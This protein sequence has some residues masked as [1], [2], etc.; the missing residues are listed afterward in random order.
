MTFRNAIFAGGGSRC[1]WQLGFWEGAKDAGLDLQTSVKFIGST[2][3]GCAMASAAVLD[4]ALDALELFKDLTDKNPK[5]VHW[6]NIHP[7]RREPLLPHARMYRE[8]LYEFIDPRDL[9]TLQSSSVHFL[10]SSYPTWLKGAI[11]AA[12]ALTIYALEMTL[13]EDP[14]HPKWPA[15]AGFRP[16]VGRSTD[17]RTLDDYIAMVLAASCVPPVLPE[18]RFRGQNVLDGGLIEN[19]PVRLAEDE[20]GKTLVLLSRKYEHPLPS[21]ERV[22]WVQPSKPIR[23]DKFDYANPRGLQ[24]TFDLGFAD[25]AS[26]VRRCA[27]EGEVYGSAQ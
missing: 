26:Y 14:L 11:G 19:I 16:L 1:F 15:K 9:P 3:A 5:N 13:R 27:P 21:N 4:R 2:S 22:T 12:A 18:G 23:I 7:S 25:G 24:E 17:C 8:A 6:W 10:M 20:P